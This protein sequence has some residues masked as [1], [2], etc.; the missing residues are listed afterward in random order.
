MKAKF[1]IL[2]VF[3]TYLN[4]H[5]VTIQLN[6][7]QKKEEDFE[8]INLTH[9]TTAMGWIE[10]S[11]VKKINCDSQI[12]KIII[13]EDVYD[14]VIYVTLAPFLISESIKIQCKEIK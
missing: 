8:E 2:I 4:C 3:Y 1:I 5:N 7:T 9:Y 11:K 14:A 13:K 6:E 10:I 12:G